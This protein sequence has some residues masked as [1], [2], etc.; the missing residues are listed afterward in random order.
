M[1]RRTFLRLLAL[2]PLLPLLKPPSVDEVPIITSDRD[3]EQHGVTIHPDSRWYNPAE[4]AW[5]KRNAAND[6]WDLLFKLDP[7][8]IPYFDPPIV[9]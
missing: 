6:G 3:I 5:F 9:S 4:G 7:R 1:E 2:A 8:I